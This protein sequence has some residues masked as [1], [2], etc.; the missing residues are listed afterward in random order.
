MPTFDLQPTL[1]G[2]LLE[3]RPLR[4]E[5]FDA[6]FAAGS[7]PLIWEVHPEKDRYTEPIFR[8]YFDGAIESGGAFAIIERKT[9]KIIGSSRYHH[10]KP[11]ESEIEIGFT[12]LE[13]KFWGGEYN[14]ELKRLM[15]EHALAFVKRVVFAAGEN[16]LRSRRALEKIGAKY[17]KMETRPARDSKPVPHAVY[18]ITGKLT[19][20][21]AESAAVASKSSRP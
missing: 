21:L 11:D 19:A 12:F 3:L 10:Y 8:R 5:D 9:G 17:F 6:L 7:D 18:A 4:R 13:R 2:N 1:K 16:N 14:R 15:V 20:E